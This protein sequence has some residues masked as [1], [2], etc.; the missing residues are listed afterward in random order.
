MIIGLTGGIATGKSTVAGLLR[1]NGLQVLDADQLAHQAI[2]PGGPAYAAV[3]REFGPDIV[4]ANRS[5][6]RKQLGK[7]VFKDPERRRRLEELVHPSV[8]KAIE[9]A[10]ARHRAGGAEQPLVVE[11][12]LLFEVGLAGLFD[13]VLMV[14]MAPEVQRRRL[15]QRDKLSNEEIETRIASQMPLTEKEA[16]ADYV[17]FNNGSLDELRRQAVNFLQS[18]EDES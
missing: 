17:I 11:V 16:R 7:I 10:I 9:A 4:K 3:I 12:P 2:E 18:L 5:I 1:E 14:S 15:Q 13:R 6:D 8:I